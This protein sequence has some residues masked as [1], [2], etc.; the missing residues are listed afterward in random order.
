[1]PEWPPS[2]PS[3]CQTGPDRRQAAG[4]KP[5]ANGNGRHAAEAEDFSRPLLPDD[6]LAELP[7][8]VAP[9]PRKPPR[10]RIE[11]A[12]L[13]VLI[14]VGAAVPIAVLGLILIDLAR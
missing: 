11:S 14:G 3:T 1:M 10:P 4:R 5:G 6:L 8:T 7:E 2:S 12:W 13:Y 9:F